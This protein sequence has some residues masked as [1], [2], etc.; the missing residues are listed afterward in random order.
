[1]GPLYQ[2]K[3]AGNIADVST[4]MFWPFLGPRLKPVGPCSIYTCIPTLSVFSVT[5]TCMRLIS[6]CHRKS[7]VDV[8]GPGYLLPQGSH[9]APGDPCWG[10]PQQGSCGCGGLPWV[11]VLQS[12]CP[13]PPLWFL[14]FTHLQFNGRWGISLQLLGSCREWTSPVH[15][16]RSCDTVIHQQC[17]VVEKTYWHSCVFVYLH[18][19]PRTAVSQYSHIEFTH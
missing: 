6:R 1:M 12:V 3:W 8:V 18:L 10:V 13:C 2:L 9:P 16:G 14:L 17:M 15:K 19:R 7:R 5:A 4:R 11:A